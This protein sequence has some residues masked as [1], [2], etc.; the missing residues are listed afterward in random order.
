MTI[1]FNKYYYTM[2]L[3]DNVTFKNRLLKD[4]KGP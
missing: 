4:I 3:T 2:F 1:I